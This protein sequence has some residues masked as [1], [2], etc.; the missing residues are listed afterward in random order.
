MKVKK[1]RHK[2]DYGSRVLKNPKNKKSQNLSHSLRSAG[3][4]F[5]T[6]NLVKF[7]K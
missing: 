7:S 5:L 2:D 6:R 3:N 1:N 4:I